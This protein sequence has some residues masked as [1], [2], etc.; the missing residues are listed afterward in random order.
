MQYREANRNLA[1]IGKALGVAYVV[2]G[3]VQRA[4]NQIRVT[5][6][7]IDAR[8][9]THKWA[10]KYD[11]PL[12]DVFTIQSDIAQAIAG[13]LQAAISPQ[14]HA[15]MTDQP[16][17]DLEAFRLYTE[18][19]AIFV[20]DDWQDAGNSLTRKVELLEQAVQRDPRFALPTAPWPRRSATSKNMPSR[21]KT[22]T[23]RISR[24]AKKA[25]ETA[26]RLRPDLGEA[27]RAMAVCYLHEMKSDLAHAEIIIALHT[28]PND[29]EA[30]RLASIIDRRQNR[31]DAALAELQKAAGLDPANEEVGYYLGDTYRK[32]RRYRD[33]E[34]FFEKRVPRNA[35]E[36]YWIQLGLAE[37]KLQTGDAAAAQTL[38][39]KIPLDFNPTEEIMNVRYTAALWRR[40]YVA[41]AVS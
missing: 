39:D 2:E 27:H 38:L 1:E 8:T 10:D 6:Q 31:W 3:S 30:L 23:T 19:V 5:A 24:L 28:L 12:T 18:A 37:C 29:T 34:Q 21:R 13:Q 9:D 7:L 26:L 4:G 40:D 20:W 32:L 35:Q 41:T 11:R 16:T 14:E 17:T 33:C 22:R 36:L 25:A 15:V